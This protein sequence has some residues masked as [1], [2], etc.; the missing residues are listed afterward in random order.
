M[1]GSANAIETRALTKR[2]G[3]IVAVDALDLDLQPGRIYGLLGPNGSGKT[4]LIRCLVGL[5][6]PTPGEAHVL[7]VKMPNRDGFVP[8]TRPDVGPTA[9]GKTK[10]RR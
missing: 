4:T 7:G 9:G 1:N 10:G 6:R 2:F 3:D 8:D 5:A